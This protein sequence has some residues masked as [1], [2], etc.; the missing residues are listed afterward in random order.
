MPL[1]SIGNV[2]LDEEFGV[3]GFEDEAGEVT[4]RLSSSL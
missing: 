1:P 2:V 4:R 3:E